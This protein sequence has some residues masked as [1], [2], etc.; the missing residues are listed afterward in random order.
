MC[1]KYDFYINDL[2]GDF[3]GAYSRF[4][5]C[6]FR[7]NSKSVEE[8]EYPNWKTVFR[9]RWLNSNPTAFRECKAAF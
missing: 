5:L 4:I 8:S 2:S 9:T 7:I 6:A 1:T 3:T